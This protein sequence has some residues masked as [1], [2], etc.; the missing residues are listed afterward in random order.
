MSNARAK[1][2]FKELYGYVSFGEMLSSIRYSEN[3]SQKSFARLLEISQQDLCDIEKGRKSVSVERAVHF[4]RLLNDSPEVFAEYVLQ[5]QLVRAGLN[6]KV[7]LG[8]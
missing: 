5:D 3:Y 2:Y 1:D 7:K 6:C 4:A 8:A